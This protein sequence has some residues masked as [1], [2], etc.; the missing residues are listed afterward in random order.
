MAPVGLGDGPSRAVSPVTV[1]QGFE[2]EPNG[3][4]SSSRHSFPHQGVDIG[5]ET[6]V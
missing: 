5:Q 6:I 2:T 1:D 3:V 4:R